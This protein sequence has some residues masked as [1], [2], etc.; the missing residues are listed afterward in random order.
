LWIFYYIFFTNIVH[1]KIFVLTIGRCVCEQGYFYNGVK[2]PGGRSEGASYP[3]KEPCQCHFLW[4]CR[5]LWHH[6]GYRHWQRHSGAYLS[7]ITTYCL[8]TYLLSL[9]WLPG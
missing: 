2:Y 3:H 9:T 5:H 8:L 4:S 6:H 7:I 1:D